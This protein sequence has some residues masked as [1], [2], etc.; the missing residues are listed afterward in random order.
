MISIEQY[1]GKYGKT[2]KDV[3]PARYANAK[4]LLVAVNKLMMQGMKEGVLFLDNP[5]T[6][7][8]ISGEQNGGFRP[9]DCPIGAPGSNHKECLAVDIYDPF[10]KVDDWLEHSLEA[11]ELYEQLGLYFEAIPNTIGWSHWQLKKPNSGRRFFIP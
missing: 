9:Q 6:K 4:R 11:R 7:S 8:Q 10:G 3:T 1:F 2:H 5:N